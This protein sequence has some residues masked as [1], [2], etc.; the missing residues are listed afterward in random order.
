VILDTKK[1]LGRDRRNLEREREREREGILQN[2]Y[3]IDYTDCSD[4][5]LLKVL[6]VKSLLKVVPSSQA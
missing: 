4:N 6:I 2:F 3:K 5:K 1:D